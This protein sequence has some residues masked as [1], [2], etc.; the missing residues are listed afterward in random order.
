MLL[1]AFEALTEDGSRS[2]EVIAISW[3]GRVS[4]DVAAVVI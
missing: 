4:L 3:R 2:Q 1:F